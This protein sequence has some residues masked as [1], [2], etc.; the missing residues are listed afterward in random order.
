MNS[1]IPNLGN[2]QAVSLVFPANIQGW[3]DSG[4]TNFGHIQLGFAYVDCSAWYDNTFGSCMNEMPD[5]QIRPVW[6]P[7]DTTSGDFEPARFYDLNGN[8][9]ADNLHIGDVY[10]FSIEAITG[11]VGQKQWEFCIKNMTDMTP[12]MCDVITRHWYAGGYQN[13]YGAEI[14]NT[15]QQLYRRNNEPSGYQIHHLEAK[16]GYSGSWQFITD[17]DCGWGNYIPPSSYY[18]CTWSF[19]S[20]TGPAISPRTFLHN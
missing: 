13:W 16:V 19:N 17:N 5:Q 9:Y 10:R 7:S 18:G 14:F 12:G 4:H 11:D 2:A 6:T 8:G 15:A 3:R 1:C 20:L